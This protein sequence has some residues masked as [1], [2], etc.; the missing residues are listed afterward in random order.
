MSL[1][2]QAL[3]TATEVE[4]YCQIKDPA[5][6]VVIEYIINSVSQEFSTFASRQFMS[7]TYTG[8][9]LTGNGT[10][11]L[12]LPNWPV[13]VLTSVVEDTATLT[14]DT[15]FYADLTEGLLTKASFYGTLYGEV[16]GYSSTPWSINTHG[17][18]VTYTA[19]YTA[20]LLPADLKLAALAEIARQYQKYLLKEHGEVSRSVEGSS[21]S[22][23][24][25]KP[26]WMAVVSRYRRIRI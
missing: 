18:V 2:A 17:I 25:E 13:T 1:I 26:D 12:Y 21:V 7:A 6:D 9:T 19:G 15:D 11:Y 24:S 3:V 5:H 20:A 16:Y 14:L 4:Q 8:L 23:T 22:M 10:K